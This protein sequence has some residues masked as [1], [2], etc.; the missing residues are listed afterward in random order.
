MEMKTEG[1]RNLAFIL[2]EA[3]GSRSRDAVTIASGEGKLEAGTVL[4]QVTASDKYAS[5]PDAEV[6]GKE[7][8]E[9][10]TAVL[11]YGV[12]ATST[13]ADAVI[14]SSD[15]EVKSPMLIYHASVDDAAKQS[16]KQSQLRAAG[17]K[18]R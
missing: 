11:A 9:I 1:A 12:D 17:I 7:G 18:S 3:G 5:S 8:A 15:A 4:G 13:D 2:S 16:T 6:A 10:A 14:L